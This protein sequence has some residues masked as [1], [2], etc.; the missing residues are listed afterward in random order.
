LLRMSG[1]RLHGAHVT[2]WAGH[3]VASTHGRERLFRG[4]H[5]ATPAAGDQPTSIDA[6]W[7]TG[8]HCD[9][10]TGGLADWR[11]GGLADHWRTRTTDWRRHW[12]MLAKVWQITGG[13]F[14][15]LANGVEMIC[16]RPHRTKL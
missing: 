3:Y 10:R 9:W 7:R 14:K 16:I 12:R 4:G 15:L 11:T 2:G 13:L 6:Q 8:G 5:S 1:G